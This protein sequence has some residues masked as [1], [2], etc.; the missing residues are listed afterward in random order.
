MLILAIERPIPSVADAQFTPDLAAA[1]ARRAWELYQAGTF[2]DLY[3]RADQSSAVLVLECG[4]IDA[5]RTVLA[6]L[7]LVVNGLTEFEV[8]PL[9]AY[10]GFGRLF[11]PGALSSER[12]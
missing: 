3:F 5:A 6:S 8:L 1:E 4:D 9:R 12:R 10:P 11:A 7:P 2:R